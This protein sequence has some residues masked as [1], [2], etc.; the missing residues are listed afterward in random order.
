MALRAA[1]LPEGD[2]LSEC[3]GGLDEGEAGASSAEQVP[4]G[5]TGSAGL[6][7]IAE[8][9]AV[10]LGL[11]NV[12]MGDALDAEAGVGTNKGRELVSEATDL[13]VSGTGS[14]G[15]QVGGEG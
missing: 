5:G 13:L 3:G 14:T 11:G 7:I 12:R 4:V 10:R 1:N 9:K 2:L 6:E 8:S 15:S